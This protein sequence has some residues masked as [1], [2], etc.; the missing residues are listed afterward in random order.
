MQC[1]HGIQWLSVEIYVNW[2]PV[3]ISQLS[4]NCIRSFFNLFKDYYYCY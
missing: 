3:G 4:N 2:Y 1:C